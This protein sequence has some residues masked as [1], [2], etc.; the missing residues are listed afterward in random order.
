MMNI[1]EMGKDGKIPQTSLKRMI[2]SAIPQ[3]I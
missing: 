3:V 2:L 1:I